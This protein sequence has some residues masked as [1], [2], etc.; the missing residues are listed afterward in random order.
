MRNYDGKRGCNPARLQKSVSQ[1]RIVM[2]ARCNL[3]E[4]VAC[5]NTGFPENE[6]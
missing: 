3:G 4:S 1:I 2:K 6:K 5:G